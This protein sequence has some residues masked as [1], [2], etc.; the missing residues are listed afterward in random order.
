MTQFTVQLHSK[1]RNK[2]RKS[3]KSFVLSDA[4]PVAVLA[5]QALM[6][7]FF[8]IVLPNWP[9]IAFGRGQL[10][11]QPFVGEIWSQSGFDQNDPHILCMPQEIGKVLYA[12]H[13][14]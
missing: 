6:S 11:L 13:Q 7:Y 8:E 10:I 5:K 12:C 3:E 14:K 4:Q 1:L 2:T 9:K